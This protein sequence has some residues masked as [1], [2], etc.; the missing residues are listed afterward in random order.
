MS[1]DTSS[2]GEKFLQQKVQ[3][4]LAV[5]GSD[6]IDMLAVAEWLIKNGDWHRKQKTAAQLCAAEL[7]KAL[8]HEM[9]LDP[10]GR[11]VRRNYAYLIEADGQRAWE[12]ARGDQIHPDNMRKAMTHRRNGM[13]ARAVQ[14]ATDVDSYNDNN[15]WGGQLELYDYDFN[16]DVEESNLPEDYPDEDPDV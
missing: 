4:W 8:A 11:T 7:S 12:W 10:Q 2:R 9:H 3:E 16:A 15:P 14:H 6:T 13:V 5:T 1:K